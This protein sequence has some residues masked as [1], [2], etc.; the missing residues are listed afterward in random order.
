MTK[1]KTTS[2]VAGCFIAS[3]FISTV[4]AIL[5]IVALWTDR[6]IEFWASYYKGE[7]VECPFWLSFAVTLLT[8]GFALLANVIAEVARL[9]I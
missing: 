4:L 1:I 9:F 6:N 8:N 7:P 2:G 5:S 3:V